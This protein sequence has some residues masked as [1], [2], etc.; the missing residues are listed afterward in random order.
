MLRILAIPMMFLVA[1]MSLP[2]PAQ[3]HASSH[4]LHLTA[5]C[6]NCLDMD[7]AALAHMCGMHDCQRGAGCLGTILPVHETSFAIARLCVGVFGGGEIQ[8]LSSISIGLDVPPP[9]A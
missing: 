1:W 2:E 9:R 7:A 6:P 5:P 4:E 3:A 8:S